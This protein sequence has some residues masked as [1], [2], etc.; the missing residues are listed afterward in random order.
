MT[1]KRKK[2]RENLSTNKKVRVLAERIRIKS[3]QEIFTN[4][5]FKIY[6]TLT[7]RK[8]FSLQK[9]KTKK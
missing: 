3:A 4:N 7:R 5:L 1:E 2:M 6:L 8:Y 9:T